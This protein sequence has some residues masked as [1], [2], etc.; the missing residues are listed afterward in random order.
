MNA[1]MN[2]N[3][4][5]AVIPSISSD[6]AITATSVLLTLLTV[7]SPLVAYPM[8]GLDEQS[9]AALKK[10]PGCT[11]SASALVAVHISNA[12]AGDIP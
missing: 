7:R 12:E 9:S 2:P 5:A 11:R 8:S 1:W 6:A 10:M 3:A 4:G